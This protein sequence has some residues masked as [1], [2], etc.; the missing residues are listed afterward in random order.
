[1]A[2]AMAM[3]AA[4]AAAAA[5]TVSE[6]N[7]VALMAMA[8][9]MAAKCTRLERSPPRYLRRRQARRVRDRRGCPLRASMWR[10]LEERRKSR[11]NATRWKYDSIYIYI[12]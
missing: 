3:A 2:M 9:A 7:L 12:E 6:A 10:C 8:L 11:T 4:A 5:A 1:M